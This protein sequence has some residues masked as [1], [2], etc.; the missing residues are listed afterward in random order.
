MSRLETFKLPQCLREISVRPTPIVSSD[1][2]FL[3]VDHQDT[4][5]LQVDHQDT[6]FLEVDHQDTGFLQ[7]D[8]QDTG[9]PRVDHQDTGFSKLIRTTGA[10]TS[11][12][13]NKLSFMDRVMK[14]SNIMGFFKLAFEVWNQ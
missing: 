12:L 13:W 4:G 8:H 11:I 14:E 9:F 3:E 6:G 5:F 2:G 7:V 10:G 1:T